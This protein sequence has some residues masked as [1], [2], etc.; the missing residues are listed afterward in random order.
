MCVGRGKKKGGGNANWS[1]NQRVHLSVKG[2]KSGP[3]SR[4]IEDKAE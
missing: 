3:V 4:K 2:L 1:K